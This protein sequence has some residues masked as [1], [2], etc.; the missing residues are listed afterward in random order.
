M[1]DKLKA[2]YK[3]SKTPTIFFVILIL[4]T[5]AVIFYNII[6]KSNI[7]D[8]DLSS[9]LKH[10]D[11]IPQRI[12]EDSKRLNEPLISS[13][14]EKIAT[15]QNDAKQEIQIVQEVLC[16]K[17]SYRKLLAD[18]NFLLISFFQDRPYTEFIN[19]IKPVYEMQ[20]SKKINNIL[21]N[22]EDYNA[23]YLVNTQS[24]TEAVI[25]DQSSIMG[26]FVKIEKTTDA[27]KNKEAL[28]KKIIDSLESLVSFT[29]SED[30]QNIFIN[31]PSKNE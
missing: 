24:L 4:I 10:P 30:F 22:L 29:Y 7:T 1:Q 19:R 14:T 20:N 17:A 28:K 5:L 25:D 23:N 9:Y 13:E 31:N 15:I 2:K 21:K 18:L 6:L 11:K 26:K 27:L 8:F 16:I 3:K 12:V